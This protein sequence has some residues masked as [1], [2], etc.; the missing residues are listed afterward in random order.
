MSM[1]LHE[2]IGVLSMQLYARVRGFGVKG[3]LVAHEVSLAIT[4]QTRDCKVSS[5]MLTCGCLSS[6]DVC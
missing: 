5:S 2:K 4:H 1:Q 6:C 3:A